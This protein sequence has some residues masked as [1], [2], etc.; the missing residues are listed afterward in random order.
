M[1]PYMFSFS[2][3]DMKLEVTQGFAQVFRWA[4]DSAL[5]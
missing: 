5:I 1:N 2:P 3:K 4:F